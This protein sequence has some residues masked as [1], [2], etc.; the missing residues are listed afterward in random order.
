MHIG[1]VKYSIICRVLTIFLF[2]ASVLNINIVVDAVWK[3]ETKST[4]CA[5]LFTEIGFGGLKKLISNG[6]AFTDLSN[7]YLKPTTKYFHEPAK[8]S[9]SWK[10]QI[11]SITTEPGCRLQICHDTHLEG[12]CT[13]VTNNTANLDIVSY[14]LN[15]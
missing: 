14:P 5:T 8:S 7:F 2:N 13:F 3:Y 6:R 9:D 4:P 10:N 15:L 11:S 1:S 12:N